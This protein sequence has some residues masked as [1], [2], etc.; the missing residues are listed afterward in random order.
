MEK[1]FN[2]EIKFRSIKM[3]WFLNVFAIVALFV[4]VATVAFSIL[5]RSIYYERIEVLAND[6]SYEFYSLSGATRNNF[7]DSAIS[8]AGQFRYKTKMEIQVIDHTGEIIVSTSGFEETNDDLT[9]FD[10]ARE[11]KKPYAFKTQS[12]SGE[13]ILSCATPLYDNDG[14][15][16]GAYRWLVSLK[17]VNRL[18]LNFTAMAIFVAFGVLTIFGLSGVYFIKSIVNPI[19]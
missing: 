8:L 4:T 6:Y 7:T 15:F 17:S 12:Q 1:R 19:K 2:L 10:K 16:L 5:F 3:R 14:E 9:D 18:S 13:D 11:T